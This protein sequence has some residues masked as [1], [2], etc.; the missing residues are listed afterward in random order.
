MTLDNILAACSSTE[1]STFNE[2][3]RAL[4]DCPAKGETAEWREV[5]GL[6]NQAEREGLVEVER[7]GK[8]I[9]SLILTDTGAERVRS[10][11]DNKRELFDLL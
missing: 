8:S 6:L 4:K 9:D 2:F 11:L 10:K 7:A 3:A 5:F 1:P